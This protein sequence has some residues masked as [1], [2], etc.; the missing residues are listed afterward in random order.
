ME[1]MWQSMVESSGRTSDLEDTHSRETMRLPGSRGPLPGL[2]VP[3]GEPDEGGPPQDPAGPALAEQQGVPDRAEEHLREC[4]QP[5][6][7]RRRRA[8]AAEDE[9]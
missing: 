5:S 9:D 2:P 7:H 8:H 1:D 4:T 6:E 3:A